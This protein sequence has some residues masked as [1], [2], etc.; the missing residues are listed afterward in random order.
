MVPVLEYVLNPC[1]FT[2]EAYAVCEQ[3]IL[4]PALAYFFCSFY[5]TGFPVDKPADML[6]SA[7]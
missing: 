4:Y 5:Y 7:C 1:I 2:L 3:E 6:V